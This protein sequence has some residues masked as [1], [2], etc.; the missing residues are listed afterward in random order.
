MAERKSPAWS[1]ALA[2]RRRGLEPPPGNPRTRPSTG[3]SP[4]RDVPS[5]RRSRIHR[6]LQKYRRARAAAEIPRRFSQCFSRLGLPIGF[7]G[8]AGRG[9]DDHQGSR[10]SGGPIRTRSRLPHAGRPQS[11]GCQ[12][13][14]RGSSPSLRVRSRIQSTISSWAASPTATLSTMPA[15]MSTSGARQVRPLASRKRAVSRNAAR[16]SASGSGWLLAMCEQ[17]GR[18]LGQRRVGLDAAERRE[19]RVQ[20][21]LGQYEPRESDNGLALDGEQEGG[22]VDVVLEGTAAS[23]A[24]RAPTTRRGGRTSRGALR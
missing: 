20:G 1:G 11:N 3:A 19:R 2:M 17:D 18:L 9:T 22:N 23:A 16:L 10:P 4:G 21:G 24:A 5:F 12:E 8:R 6:D 13:M 14:P 7:A 15:S